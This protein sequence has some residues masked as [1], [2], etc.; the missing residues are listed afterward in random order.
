MKAEITEAQRAAR[1]KR[2]RVEDVITVYG[3][4]INYG[5]KARANRAADKRAADKVKKM[6]SGGAVKKMNV[7]GQVRGAG[8][9]QRGV[10]PAKMR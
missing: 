3:K 4:K 9:A 7:G 1:E 5:R 10:R 8:I 2:S 6:N